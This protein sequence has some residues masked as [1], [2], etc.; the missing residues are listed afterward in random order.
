MENTTP[1]AGPNDPT[2]PTGPLSLDQAVEQIVD[3]ERQE[4]LGAE[5]R[6]AEDVAFLTEAPRIIEPVEI[7][8]D[9]VRHM[10]LPFWALRRFQKATGVSPWDHEKLW[11]FPPDPDLIVHLLWAALLDEDP[12]ITP[13]QVER[14]PGMDLAN[15]LYL[16]GRLDL[17]WG[18]NNPDLEAQVAGAAGG[19]VP[20]P[21]PSPAA[22]PGG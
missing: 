14:M 22:S 5:A 16:R 9:R 4:R 21:A 8:L 17:L 10:R 13:A 11:G 15:M 7:Q 3:E 12:E 19:T 1:Y 18:R 2:V 6:A 20:N